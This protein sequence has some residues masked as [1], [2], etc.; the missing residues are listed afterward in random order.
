[1]GS[2]LE[3]VLL[4]L[5]ALRRANRSEDLSALIKTRLERAWP[6]REASVLR[7]ELIG[8]CHRHERYAEAL[9]YLEEQ[10]ERE[11][12][13]PLHSLS[14]AEHFHYYDLNLQQSIAHVA[15]AITKARADGKFLYQALGVQARVAIELEDWALLEATLKELASYEHAPG[16]VDVFPETDFLVRIPNG[17]VSSTALE[18]YLARVEHLRSIGYST[19]YGPKPWPAAN[20]P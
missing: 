7:S 10:V 9:H 14:L 11:P 8:E 20:A 4:E 13:E 3:S 19:V 2:D 5:Q 17:T 18:A 1:M 12:L 15:D 16:N 6:D